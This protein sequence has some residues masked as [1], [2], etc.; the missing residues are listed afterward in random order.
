MIALPCTLTP[1]TVSSHTARLLLVMLQLAMVAP[2]CVGAQLPGLPCTCT[3]AP[4]PCPQPNTW[5]PSMVT[6]GEP[7]A[8]TAAGDTA[9]S[10]QRKCA[11][12]PGDTTPDSA[13]LFTSTIARV[14]GKPAAGATVVLTNTRSTPGSSGRGTSANHAPPRS[15]KNDSWEAFTSAG[16]GEGG[17]GSGA[18]WTASAEA[19]AENVLLMGA[20]EPEERVKRPFSTVPLSNAAETRASAKKRS[21]RMPCTVHRRSVCF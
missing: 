7:T 21:R 11:S 4:W 3:A 5:M 15:S 6:R 2:S 12:A 18:K 19:S 9:A 13:L 16:P 17:G 14:G 20:L 1:R 10:G 8:H